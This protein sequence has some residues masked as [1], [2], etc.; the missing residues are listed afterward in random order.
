MN[1]MSGGYKA[2]DEASLKSVFGEGF[3][4]SVFH[5]EKDKPFGYSE[6]DRVVVCGGDGTLNSVINLYRETTA[7]IFYCPYGTL[8]E[9]SKRGGKSGEPFEI[10][11]GG[12]ASGRY[13]SYVLATGTFTPLGYAVENR[14]KQ[15]IKSMAYIVNV[16]KQLKVKRVK[17]ELTVD[18]VTETGEYSLIMAIDSRQCF[19]LKFN[20]LFKPNDGKIH[21]LTVKSPRF[22]G[23]FGLV[24]MFFPFFR[25]FFIG[26]KKPYKS[27][28]AEFREFKSLYVKTD[29]PCDFC[30][31]GEK[32]TM[33]REF[34]VTP[35]KLMPPITVF[36]GKYLKKA[37]KIKAQ[38]GVKKEN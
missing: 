32:W 14:V 12:E 4:T 36:S 33:P 31:D 15:K 27:K 19:G 25:A 9:A 34:N 21:L 5:I 37:A 13:F 2:A 10:T 17:A 22:N 23:L 8:N 26:F 3:S 20:K 24:E 28:R 1:N 38:H 11:D 35:A 6:A 7:E 30:V 29:A 16:L 18:G